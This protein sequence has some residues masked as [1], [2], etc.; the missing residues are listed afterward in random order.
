[1]RLRINFPQQKEAARKRVA[2]RHTSKLG[3]MGRDGFVATFTKDYGR[4]STAQEIGY[5]TY[6]G[7]RA[8]CQTLTD[9][10]DPLEQ[11][12]EANM[13]EVARQEAEGRHRE[14]ERSSGPITGHD[15]DD[16][17]D[18]D[19]RSPTVRTSGGGTSDH[20]TDDSESSSSDGSHSDPA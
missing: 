13:T 20:E 7:Y 9:T 14:A 19:S 10:P 2:L 4:A 8:L 15:G 17:R 1:M 16:R 12:G 18:G 11:H 5:A 6:C 3:Q